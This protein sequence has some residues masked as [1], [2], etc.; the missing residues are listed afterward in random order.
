MQLNGTQIYSCFYLAMEAKIILTNAF[1][2]YAN[3]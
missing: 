3:G 1:D 2:Q